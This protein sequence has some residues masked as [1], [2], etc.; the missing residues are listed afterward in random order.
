MRNVQLDC[1]L[2]RVHDEGRRDSIQN[3]SCTVIGYIRFTVMIGCLAVSLS[4]KTF[5]KD[6]SLEARNCKTVD[7]F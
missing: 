6:K 1:T 5:I 3:D 4:T 7:M 2:R